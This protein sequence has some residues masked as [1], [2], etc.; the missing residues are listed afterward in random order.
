LA[1]SGRRAVV[2]AHSMLGLEMADDRLDGVDG[3][4]LRIEGDKPFRSIRPPSPKMSSLTSLR[5]L[6]QIADPTSNVIRANRLSNTVNCWH[7]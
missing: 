3:P 7:G 4:N 5:D 2:S 1:A 6:E